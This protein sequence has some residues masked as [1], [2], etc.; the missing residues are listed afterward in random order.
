MYLDPG[1]GSMLIQIVA[2]SFAALATMLGIFRHKVKAF[3]NRKKNNEIETAT[4]ED[5]I[6]EQQ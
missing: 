3:F 1:F 5:T 2:A 6:N 4:N